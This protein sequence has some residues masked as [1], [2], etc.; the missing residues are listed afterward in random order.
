MLSSVWMVVLERQMK[1]SGALL[2]FLAE[3]A[4]VRGAAEELAS[5]EMASVTN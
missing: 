2:A 4:D 1:C 5:S 3:D